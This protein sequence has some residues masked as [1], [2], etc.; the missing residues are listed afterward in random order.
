MPC[1]R[2]EAAIKHHGSET[3]LNRGGFGDKRLQRV[4][5]RDHHRPPYM[6]PTS[7]KPDLGHRN[8]KS[9]RGMGKPI[10]MDQLNI[11]SRG[12]IGKRVLQG[13]IA[14]IDVA[15]HPKDDYQRPEE[16]FLLRFHS[17]SRGT[18]SYTP[19]RVTFAASGAAPVI[20]AHPRI[21][22]ARGGEVVWDSKRSNVFVRAQVWNA[23]HIS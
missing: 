8:A 11:A 9:H 18:L 1:G 4:C 16:G 14:S 13:K 2:G 6:G 5:W 15:E 23:M 22:T 17:S 20:T 10:G 21:E 12:R 19:S 3:L 7:N